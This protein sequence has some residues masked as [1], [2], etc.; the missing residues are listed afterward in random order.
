MSE[1]KPCPFCGSKAKLTTL[2][3]EPAIACTLCPAIMLGGSVAGKLDL[4][5]VWNHRDGAEGHKKGEWTEIQRDEPTDLVA[6]NEC[7][8]CHNA[9]WV[10]RRWDYCP[11]CG[12]DMREEEES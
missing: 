9:I 8:L 1:L 12:A 7:S 6:R 3:G 4:V 2:S 5:I 11:N 10:D